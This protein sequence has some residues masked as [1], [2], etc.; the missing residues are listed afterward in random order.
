MEARQKKSKNDIG[1]QVTDRKII[2]QAKEHSAL[3]FS[4]RFVSVIKSRILWLEIACSESVISLT[5]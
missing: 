3:T 1:V 2:N 4:S 5:K